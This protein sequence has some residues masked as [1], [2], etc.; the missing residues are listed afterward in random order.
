MKT[1]LTSVAMVALAFGLVACGPNAE[2]TMD[3]ATNEAAEAV[4]AA[5]NATS[6]VVE[7]T[8][9]A[10]TPTPSGQ[11][12]VDRAAK[13]DAFEIAAAKLA[14][15][16]A[17]SDAVKAFAQDMAKAHTDSTAKIKAAAKEAMPAITPQ[18]ALTGEQNDTLADLGKLKGADFD[19]K[20]MSG[21]VEAHEDALA[22]MENYSKNGDVAPLKAVAAEIAPV[23]KRHLDEAR[24][25]KL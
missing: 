12:F 23:V 22:L 13:S 21:Q 9:E 20:Y 11:E 5:G 10:I 18:P 8:K 6:D 25:L 19:R 24:A 17:A 2:Q 1:A 7:A 3:T 14:L 4:A 16:N 15:T